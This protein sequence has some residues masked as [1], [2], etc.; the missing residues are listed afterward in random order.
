MRLSLT[1]TSLLVL[2]AEPTSAS[3]LSGPRV[4]PGT[5]PKRLEI[6]IGSR[7]LNLR[8]S[9]DLKNFRAFFEEK[10]KRLNREESKKEALI[11]NELVEL[12]TVALDPLRARSERQ[13]ALIQAAEIAD[14]FRNENR[15][16]LPK[17]VDI[18][19]TAP[20]V[21]VDYLNNPFGKGTTRA[22]NLSSFDSRDSSS[23]DPV[24]STFWSNP[25]DVSARDTF[26]GFGRRELPDFSRVVCKYKEPKESL[27]AHAGFT[28]KCAEAEVKVKFGEES[29]EPFGARIFS[30]LGFNTEPTDFTEEL[31]FSYSRKYFQ[32]FNLRQSPTMKVSVAGVPVAKIPLFK[33]FNPFQYIKKAILKDGREIPG[34]ELPRELLKRASNQEPDFAD[35]NFRD[36]FESQ[37]DSLVILPANI[38]IKNKKLKSV[39]AWDWNRLEH[40]KRR[41]L[42][43]MGLLAAWL[44]WYDPRWDN[45]RIKIL[46][47]DRGLELRHYVSDVGSVLGAAATFVNSESGEV[48]R[49]PWTFTKLDDGKLKFEGFKLAYDDNAPFKNIPLL[50]LASVHLIWSGRLSASP[51]KKVIGQLLILNLSVLGAMAIFM[52]YQGLPIPVLLMSALLVIMSFL[53]TSTVWG[54]HLYATGGNREAAFLSGVSVKFCALSV[55]TLMGL[56]S[57]LGGIVLTTRVGSASPDAGQLLE[58]DAIASCVIGGTSLAGGKGTVFG[59]VLGALLIESL[60]NGMSLANMEPFWQFI[61]KGVVLV[62][63]V[64]VDVVSRE[65]R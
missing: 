9:I 64:W 2:A 1:I 56:M 13:A 26:F 30:A 52:S 37:I 33:F 39:G 61:L 65:Q 8:N 16:P 3:T 20:F 34:S 5:I 4:N 35:S 21:V 54:R 63:A 60:N 27:G 23:A 11:Y 18:P 47:T 31:R 17:Q 59:A 25:G 36:E 48:N 15:S 55:L 53:A 51:V 38:Q 24:E 45:T 19:F 28:A 44:N 42:R 46:E 50:V 7:E 41:E 10:L 62:G 40:D 29:S 32:D 57:A 12:S 43:G 22:N 49:Y 14:T 58:L 6:E